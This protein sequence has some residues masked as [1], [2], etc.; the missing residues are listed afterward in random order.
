MSH[1][2]I[3]P[4]LLTTPEVA[5]RLLISKR[6]VRGQPACH[7]RIALTKSIFSLLAFVTLLATVGLTYGA[8]SI[9]VPDFAD[10]EKWMFVEEGPLIFPAPW[11]NYEIGKIKKYR[12]TTDGFLV[13]F[14]E[15][16]FGS[17]QPYWKR[18]GLEYSRLTY[19]ALRKKDSEGWTVGSPGSYWHALAVFEGTVLKAMWF[20]LFVPPQEEA[21]G[22]YFPLSTYLLKE[23]AQ[24]EKSQGSPIRFSH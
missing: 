1:G 24:P 14:E 15:F 20:V 4:R 7:K 12:H 18:W 16:L 22:R 23:T 13:G 10:K 9:E 6:K 17:E 19:H 21:V 11:V 5:A 2:Q 3:K 8:G